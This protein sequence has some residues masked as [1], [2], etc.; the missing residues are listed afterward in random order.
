MESDRR[1]GFEIDG[2]TVDLEAEWVPEQ[3]FRGALWLLNQNV[4]RHPWIVGIAAI[5]AIVMFAADVQQPW[6]PLAGIVAVVVV[7]AFATGGKRV[8]RENSDKLERKSAN[9]SAVGHSPK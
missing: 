2:K 9:E 6:V 4:G 5:V 8:E 7:I 3:R 1:T